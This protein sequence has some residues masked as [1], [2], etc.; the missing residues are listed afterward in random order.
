MSALMLAPK[1][2][3]GRAAQLPAAWTSF[4]GSDVDNERLDS[5]TVLLL[6]VR[7]ARDSA[8][9]DRLFQTLSARIHG[10]LLH[11][12]GCNRSD[13]EQLLQDIWSTV[14][15]K[16]A[17]FDPTRAAAR[18]WIFAI[19]RNAL[20]E[21]KRADRRERQVFVQ[22]TATD[23]ELA[24]HH[25]DRHAAQADGAKTWALL[26]D[27]PAEQAQVLLMAYVEGKSHREIADELALPVGTVKSRLR[28]GFTRVRA[29]LEAPPG[30]RA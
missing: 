13:G 2:A 7:D 24:R 15:S 1:I 21:L 20:I 6:R 29:L 30:K 22:M 26:R 17:Q 28:L 16:S 18:T 19:A 10:Y 11:S 8:A 25:D 27:L 14:W 5:E 3:C 23:L 4:I 12:G 9:F